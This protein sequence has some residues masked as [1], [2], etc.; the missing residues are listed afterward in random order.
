METYYNEDDEVV[1]GVREL[2]AIEEVAV[3]GNLTVETLWEPDFWEEVDTFLQKAP[4]GHEVL[5]WFN[6]F[7]DKP[8]RI[9]VR[10]SMDRSRAA[11]HRHRLDSLYRRYRGK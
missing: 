9:E 3:I 4:A 2:S 10:L 8:T 1:Y 11:S 7:S 5:A 6:R